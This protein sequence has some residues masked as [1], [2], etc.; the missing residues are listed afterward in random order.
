MSVIDSIE[1]NKLKIALQQVENGEDIN[2]A[3]ANAEYVNY[4]QKLIDKINI[5]KNIP[6]LNTDIL[7]YLYSIKLTDKISDVAPKVNAIYQL[8][9][10]SKLIE[11]KALDEKEDEDEENPAKKLIGNT[12][13][14][15]ATNILRALLNINKG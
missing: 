6:I 1:L 13:E 2:M 9:I 15:T 3:V 10:A 5:L 4:D 14:D 8:A 12:I 7:K 11:D